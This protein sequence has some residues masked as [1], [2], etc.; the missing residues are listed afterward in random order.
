M[1]HFISVIFPTRRVKKTVVEHMMKASGLPLNESKVNCGI[2]ESDNKGLILKVELPRSLNEKESDRFADT[3]SSKLFELGYQDFDIESS[4]SLDE[5]DLVSEEALQ[6][7]QLLD[8]PGKVLKGADVD[9]SMP[10]IDAEFKNNKGQ[11]VTLRVH[12]PANRLEKFISVKNPKILGNGNGFRGNQAAPQQTAPQTN[13][14]LDADSKDNSPKSTAPGAGAQ[15][16]PKSIEQIV[17]TYAKPGMSLAELQQMEADLRAAEPQDLPKDETSGVAGFFKKIG[18]SLN[19]LT[20]TEDYRVRTGFAAAAWKLR[21]PGLYTSSGSFVYM[22]KDGQPKSAAGASLNQM[23]PLAKA[24]LLTDEKV[25][26]TVKNFEWKTKDIKPGDVEARK[27]ADKLDAIVAA[28]EAAKGKAATKN[29]TQEPQNAPQTSAE[30]DA[31][32]KDSGTPPKE[33]DPFANMNPAEARKAVEERITKLMDLLDKLGESSVYSQLMTMLVEGPQED[34]EIYKLAKEINLLLPKMGEQFA[35]YARMVKSQLKRAEAAI[36]RH[37]T[38]LKAGEKKPD[39]TKPGEFSVDGLPDGYTATK[40]DDHIKIFKDGKEVARYNILPDDTDDTIKDSVRKMAN[41]NAGV[42]VGGPIDSNVPKPTELPPAG[43][44]DK[45]SVSL[46]SLEKFAS[47]GKGGLKNDPDEK[48]AI[49]ELQKRLNDMGYDAGPVDGIYGRKTVEAVKQFQKDYGL[50]VDGDAGPNTIAE[51][52]KK[53]DSTI[54]YTGE[55]IDA[56]AQKDLKA[57]GR[58]QGI[59]GEPLTKEDVDA[60]NKGIADNTIQAR[61]IGWA[62]EARKSQEK[63][64]EDEKKPGDE[65]KADETS[66]GVAPIEKQTKGKPI[67]FL[68][69]GKEY[70]AFK[71]PDNGDWYLFDTAEPGSSDT[72]KF[73]LG[74]DSEYFDAIESTDKEIN[75]GEAPKTSAGT[76]DK[77]PAEK[78][79]SGADEV[80]K[81]EEG[82]EEAPQFTSY[83]EA[84]NSND[85][86]EG[87]TIKIDGVEFDVVVIDGSTIPQPKDEAG[88]KIIQGYIDEQLKAL[89]DAVPK[90]NSQ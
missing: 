39:E 38:A 45:A 2:F 13:A 42:K 72:P 40:A 32:S 33:S 58:D 50:K 49:K 18:R 14:E 25:A 10:Y 64:P 90:E 81:P 70:Y 1:E 31:D 62:D 83:E 27:I 30:L 60:L 11:V 47:S 34:A 17:D 5:K 22:D 12:G 84:A 44:S 3:L 20:S 68:V 80:E 66:T 86:K 55:P 85:L 63:K 75:S 71:H 23:L 35:P 41:M 19:Q 46:P 73:R 24:G 21:L 4:V 61:K 36:A 51:L 65:K 9:T 89:E 78:S 53:K 15:S 26:K 54:Y 79:T 57:V 28:H 8:Q 52:T 77:P 69:K 76:G 48:E 6:H 16:G 7:I 37:E 67:V 74:K 82:G 59:I 29:D 87:T 56:Q 88:R 43:K